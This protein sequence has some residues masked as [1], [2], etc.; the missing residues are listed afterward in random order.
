MTDE[1]TIVHG[2]VDVGA[3]N[4]VDATIDGG[5][6]EALGFRFVRLS[7]KAETERDSTDFY[8]GFSEVDVIH[9]SSRKSKVATENTEGEVPW[10]QRPYS[11]KSIKV[12][13]WIVNI[14]IGRDTP[15][16]CCIA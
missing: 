1:G 2:P 11:G 13:E 6:D 7:A 3:V 14:K 9:R 10:V 4:E 15:T 16:I 12:R 8:A 5:L